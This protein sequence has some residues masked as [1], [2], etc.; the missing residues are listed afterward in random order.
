M[1]NEQLAAFIK[2]GDSEELKPILWER[3]KP[4]LY[5]KADYEYK[6][7]D[8]LFEKCGI[9]EWDVRQ[10]CYEVYLKA[11][12]GYKPDRSELFTTYLTYP[13]Q[14]VLNDLLGTRNGKANNK[15]LDNCTSLDK[16]LIGSEGEEMYLVDIIED[17][18]LEPH[19]DQISRRDR[20]RIVRQAVERLNE[21]YR[22][23]IRQHYFK[24]MTYG[25]IGEEKGL[26]IERIRQL[27]A[28]AVRQLRKDEDLRLLVSYG[29]LS[30]IGR[31]FTPYYDWGDGKFFNGFEDSEEYAAAMHELKSNDLSYGQRQAIMYE[32]DYQFQR[33]R[34]RAA[35]NKST[36][37]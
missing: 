5:K 17:T 8:W 18:E 19:D 11:L 14:N 35:V 29:E 16:P 9:E 31:Q 10:A 30:R 6:L 12:N 20:K 36:A 2:E 32:A 4:I 23:V 34:R 7:R 33:N 28:K 3:V 15:P 1:T 37:F 22:T 21:P 27:C 13:F 25:Q 26:S 24:G